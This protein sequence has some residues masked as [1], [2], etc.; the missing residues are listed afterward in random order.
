MLQHSRSVPARQEYTRNRDRESSSP[1]WLKNIVRVVKRVLPPDSSSGKA[2]LQELPLDMALPPSTYAR[3]SGIHFE[4][5]VYQTYGDA[6]QDWYPD[7]RIEKIT[8]VTPKKGKR[9]GAHHDRPS[10]IGLSIRAFMSTRAATEHAVVTEY[11]GEYIGHGQS[12]TIFKLHCQ[13]K[14][15][16]ACIL[17]IR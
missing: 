2:L 1:C 15:F 5:A 17:K 12:K 4:A 7:I 16:D 9:I 3:R 11:S 13:S 8:S 14:I 10:D 6:P